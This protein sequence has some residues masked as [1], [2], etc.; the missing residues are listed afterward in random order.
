MSFEIFQDW[1]FSSRLSFLDFVGGLKWGTIHAFGGSTPSN[2]KLRPRR[3]ML[4]TITSGEMRSNW[5]PTAEP[6]R[7]V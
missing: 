4:D 6:T 1:R 3:E 7:S 5:N 2:L